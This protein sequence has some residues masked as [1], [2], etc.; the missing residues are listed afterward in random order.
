MKKRVLSNIVSR[1]FGKF[2]S[3]RFHP[4]LQRFINSSYVKLLKLDM[5]E[6]KD[7][8]EYESLNAL[9]TRALQKRRDIEDGVIAPTDSLI[10]QVGM[11]QHNIALQ[12]KGMQYSI[13]NLLR[14]CD[15]SRIYN[16]EYINCYLSPRDYH[17]YHMPYT[18]RI[19]RVVHIPGKL[20][21]VNLRYLCKKFNL[22]I[23][24]E[25]VILECES[26]E[27]KTIFIV[28]VGA[29]NV[30][31]MT[32]VFESR[33]ETNRA[34]EIAIYEY[35]DLWLQKGELLGY[36]KMGST[37]LLFFEKD[38]CKL[39]VQSNTT[40]KFGQQIAKVKYGE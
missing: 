13:D 37:V 28:L 12:I 15:A 34:K 17:R 19:K 32:L 5:D 26:Q 10:T 20:Y 11:L 9:F 24:N 8:N 7:P 39:V 3:H 30:G 23:E 38:F 40:V 4:L 14:E 31:Q 27:G 29:L 6:F 2:A 25:R 16:G 36:F 1:G 33:I 22:F 35:K 21:P 18:L